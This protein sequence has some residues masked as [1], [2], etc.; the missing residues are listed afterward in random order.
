MSSQS[1]P[2]RHESVIV[3]NLETGVEKVYVGITPEQAVVAA[4]ESETQKNRAT[5]S[6]DQSKAIK[7][8]SGKT[9]ICGDWCAFIRDKGKQPIS[10][11]KSG[12]VLAA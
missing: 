8:K 5:W 4:Y 10:L 2:I 11:S 7:S 1:S 9:V 6:Y 3:L 12:I